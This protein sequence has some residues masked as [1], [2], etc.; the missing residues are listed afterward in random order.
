MTAEIIA[1]TAA[2]QSKIQDLRKY[3]DRRLVSLRTDRWSYWQHWRQL[4]DFI[5]PRRGRYLMSPNQATRGDPVGSRMINETPIFALRTLAAGLMAGLTS[6]ARPWFRLTLRDIDSVDNTPVRLW[7]DE[8]TKRILNV[9][10]QSNAYNALHV[11]YEELGCFGTGCMLVETDYEDVIRCQT[12]TAGEYY[13]ASSG[14]NEIDT[15]YREYVLTV[16]QVVERFGLTAASPQVKSLWISGQLDKEINVAQAIE[17]N[18]DRAPQIPG[19]RGRKYRSIIWEWGQSQ[20]LVLELKGYY[21]LPFCAPRWHVIGND[22]Y[23]RSPGMEALGS[24]KMLQQ[25]EKR[26]AQAIDKVLNPPMVADVSMKNEPASLLPGGVTYVANMQASGFKPAYQVPPDIRG[27][28][29]KIAKC[30]D[31]IN[32][33]FF[34]DLFLMIS[35]LDTVRTATEIIER[36][37]EKMLMLGPFLERSQFELINPF[38]DRTFAIM[39]R[40]GLVPRH[41]PR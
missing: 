25:L 17:P 1:I 36:K 4:S 38:I 16:G 13:L 7:L 5:L 11:I 23:G 21:E 29:E 20:T 37:Q 40:A 15:L 30:E 27:A 6:P 35:Q 2:R 8:V 3:L 41:R 34:A 22:S 31:R 14:R 10:S 24:S 28:E 39:F 9:L 26:T 12:L 33:A 18:D 19:L 32:R